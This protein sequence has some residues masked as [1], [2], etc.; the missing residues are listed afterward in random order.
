LAVRRPGRL[1]SPETVDMV[2]TWLLLLALVMAGCQ[3]WDKFQASLTGGT[4]ENPVLGDP[5][6]RYRLPGRTAESSLAA[7]PTTQTAA[8]GVLP[9]SL[10]GGIDDPDGR[11]FGS[12][13]VAVVNGTPIL[14]SD[15]L[16]R[17]SAQLGQ[18]RDKATP[19]EFDKLRMQLIRRDLNGHIE[20]TLLA[21]ALRSTIP[22]DRMSVLDEFIDK[23]FEER[24]AQLKAE[25]GVTSTVELDEL[26]KKEN[27]SVVNLKSTFATERLA[28]EYLASKS[29]VET[30]IGRRELLEYYE[31]HKDEDYFVPGRVRWQQI[32]LSYSKW[33]DKPE[34]YGVLRKVIEELRAGADF[35][36]VARRYSDGPRASEGGHWDWTQKGSLAD[37]QVEQALFGLP[38]GRISQYLEGDSAIQIVKIT[39]RTEDAYKPF[40]DVQAEIKTKLE[41][42]ARR[43][44]AR[45][46]IEELQQNAVVMTI[47]DHEGQPE[48]R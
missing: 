45:Q 43:A 21:Q 8:A 13:T 41:E 2:R 24:L 11:L 16:E 10:T 1:S 17:Y 31:A 42:E 6:P 48:T 22:A 36:D 15:V 20:R 37:K 3:Q 44:A 38:V 30:R 18:A 25:A 12:Q 9:V 4:T 39:A 5:P 46:V 27:T 26:L 32:Q 19:E 35:G 47:F 14:A 33:G 28:M 7:S 23:M 29:K 40:E 34:T